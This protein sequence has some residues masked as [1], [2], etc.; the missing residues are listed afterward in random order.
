[1]CA[2]KSWKSIVPS[3]AEYSQTGEYN[4]SVLVGHAYLY[5]DPNY[6]G[7]GYYL[8]MD[9]NDLAPGQFTA[10]VGIVTLNG[11]PDTAVEASLTPV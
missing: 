3:G 2:A 6:D 4:L 11:D 8:S 1:M 9:G 7:V 5:A 10:T